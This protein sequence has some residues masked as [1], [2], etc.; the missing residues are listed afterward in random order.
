M[1]V[2]ETVFQM[3]QTYPTLYRSRVMALAHIFDSYHAEWKEG[4]LI[5][6][7]PYGEGRD[8]LPYP[9]DK[10]V[11]NAEN[12]IHDV[13][14]AREE[15][16]KAQFVYDNADLLSQDTGSRFEADQFV[17]FKGRH[18]DDLPETVAKDWLDAA[19]ELASTVLAHKPTA[20]GSYA[21]EYVAQQQRSQ[22]ESADIC[23]QFLERF[24]PPKSMCLY[25]RAARVTE[26]LRE[27]RA[28]GLV[29]TEQDGSQPK[30]SV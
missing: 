18:F 13:L 5:S 11:V 17:T 21:P 1:N 27:A 8:F 29:L 9:P 12:R 3:M 24:L 2:Q 16:A 6:R 22:K 30:T 25:A 28:L 20:K 14:F 19:K 7:E 26:L 23:R 15:N 4:E 10:L